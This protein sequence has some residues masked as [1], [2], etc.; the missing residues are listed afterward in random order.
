MRGIADGIRHGEEWWNPLTDEYV[1]RDH[2]YDSEDEWRWRGVW[3]VCC[4]TKLGEPDDSDL[5]SPLNRYDPNN[6][7]DVQIEDIA[8]RIE[9]EPG[10]QRV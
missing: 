5:P 6:D 8:R 7:T 1:F 10:W 2:Q 3:D 9:R 4:L